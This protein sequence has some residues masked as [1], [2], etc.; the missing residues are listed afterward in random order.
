[1][2]NKVDIMDVVAVI[3]EQRNSALNALAETSATVASLRRQIKGA[4]QNET[5]TEDT[6]T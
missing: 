2:T 5:D 3:I 6:T 4:N 1:M